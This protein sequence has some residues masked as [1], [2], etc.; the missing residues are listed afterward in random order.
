MLIHFDAAT[1]RR[2]IVGTRWLAVA[3]LVEGQQQW[4]RWTDRRTA[5]EVE[6]EEL[7]IALINT[8]PIYPI[9][10]CPEPFKRMVCHSHRVCQQNTIFQSQIRETIS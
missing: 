6:L 5:L 9:V 8:S 3:G 1:V 7:S 4:E 10:A 2:V